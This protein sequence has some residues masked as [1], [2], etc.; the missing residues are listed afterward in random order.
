MNFIRIFELLKFNSLCLQNG[1]WDSG[2]E[3]FRNEA[4]LRLVIRDRGSE[5]ETAPNTERI[6]VN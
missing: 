4:E 3:W 1:T 5:S 6:P 2:E